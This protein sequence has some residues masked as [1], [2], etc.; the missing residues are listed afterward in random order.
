MAAAFD[1]N[2]PA[3]AFGLEGP[4]VAATFDLGGPAAAVLWPLW[5]WCGLSCV[6]GIFG[7]NLS[8]PLCPWCGLSGVGGTFSPNLSLAWPWYGLSGARGS[9]SPSLSLIGVRVSFILRRPP[10]DL[11]FRPMGKVVRLV[12]WIS[13]CEAGLAAGRRE[14]LRERERPC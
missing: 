4:A 10:G 6:G 12:L 3:A 7:P 9:F 5:P 11:L 1:L 13:L 2:D 14:R 8:R